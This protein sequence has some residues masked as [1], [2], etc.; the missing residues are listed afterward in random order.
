MRCP[1]CKSIKVGKSKVEGYYYCGVC[2]AI[3]R[4]EIENDPELELYKYKV[5]CLRSKDPN[6]EK[7]FSKCDAK[8]GDSSHRVIAT[9]IDRQTGYSLLFGQAYFAVTRKKR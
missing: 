8:F 1:F 3:I 2:G 9:I 7:I 5:H 4:K 6:V